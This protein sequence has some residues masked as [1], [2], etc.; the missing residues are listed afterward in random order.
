MRRMLVCVVS[1][2]LLSPGTALAQASRSATA[3]TS[4]TT[5]PAPPGSRNVRAHDPS[6]ILRHG[7][8]YWF[9]STGTG[10]RTHRSR[11]L[12]NWET[13]PRAIEVLP[14]WTKPYPLK[15]DRVWAPDVIRAP[16]GRYFLYYSASSWGKNTSAIGLAINPTLDPADPAYRWVDAGVVIATTAADDFNAIDPAVMLDRDGRMWMTFGSYWSGIK[17]I[18]LDPRTGVRVAPDSE[19]YAL[20]DAKEIEAPFIHP[21]GRWYY[22]FVNHGLCCRGVRSTYETRVGRSARITGPYLDRDGKDLRHAGGTPVLASEPQHQFFGP[23]HASIVVDEKGLE[24]LSFHFYD[25]TNRGRGT[26]GIRRLTWTADGWPE[27]RRE[28]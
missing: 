6:T 4:P 15:E 5:L 18:E 7:Q 10:V 11:D 21:R 2:S 22:L 1:L 24:W 25:G 13:G 20:A 14:E 12:L 27:V 3:A 19:V 8:E 26:L 23:G 16:D 9:F 28:E 17:L